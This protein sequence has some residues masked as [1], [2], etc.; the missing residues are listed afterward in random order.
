MRRFLILTIIALSAATN[1]CAQLCYGLDLGLDVSRL[2][3]SKSVVD[4]KNRAG[5]F[6]G[7]KIHAKIPKIGLGADIALR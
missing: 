6:L 5:F 1:A 7:P 4:A 2:G 3:F